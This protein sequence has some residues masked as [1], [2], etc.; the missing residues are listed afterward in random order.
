[1]NPFICEILLNNQIL[2]SNNQEAGM[3]RFFSVLALSIL[4]VSLFTAAAPVPNTTFTL[5]QGLP[6]TMNVGESYTVIVQVDSDQQFLSAQALPSFQFPGKGVVAVQGGDR[7]VGDT[8]ATL[9]ITFKAKSPTARMPDGAAPV[10]VVVGVRYPG[11]YVAVQ[12][13]LFNVTVP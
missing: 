8:S 9:A 5:V 12:D 4:M 13:Y 3:K 2:L 6:S 7:T 10:H 1:M 11:G